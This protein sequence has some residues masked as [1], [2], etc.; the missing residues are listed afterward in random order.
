MMKKLLLGSTALVVG[1]LMAAPAMAA[2]PIKIGVGGY[3]T[4]Y[5]GAGSIGSTYAGNGT[6][7]NYKGIEFF[8]EGEI[9]FIGQSK[10]DNGTT[11]GL[12]V[13]LEGHN[14]SSATA[15]AQIDEAFLF[16]FGDWGRVE[17]GAKDGA[18]YIMQYTTPSALIGFGFFNPNH[19]YG[20]ASAVANNKAWHGAAST[21]IENNFQDVNRINYYTPRF[22]GLQIGVGYAP[23]INV[24]APGGQVANGTGGLAGICGYA[25]ATNQANCPSADYSYQ[26]MFDVGVNYLN[27][28]GDVS[29]AL[30]AGYMNAT[31]VPGFAPL[32]GGANMITGANMTNWKAA[33]VGANISFAG[34]TLGGNVGWDN[35]GLGANYFTGVDND[36]R[37]YTV[38]LMYETGAWQISAGWAGFRN[39]NGNGSS[40]VAAIAPG[41]NTITLNTAAAVGV[42]G[43]NSTAFGGGAASLQFGQETMDKFEIGANYALGPG[44]KLVG[45]FTY[46]QLG[47]PTNA[48]S[49]D[50]WVA[51][52]GM[53]LRF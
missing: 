9:H 45:G 52:L 22:A 43:V 17:F 28:F 18:A 33:V 14:P 10:L 2:D 51:L 38:G 53:D 21:T 4:F 34:F 30:S 40:T 44:I 16:A 29:I 19:S 11:V 47:G 27:K 35:N 26:D 41:T 15:N 39:T 37:Y 7:T 23:K 48:V 24:A 25:N 49:G 5:A 6:V 12:R 42:P 13:E 1:G 8:Q 31:F 50:S 32:A 20:N 3:Y 46:F 36:T